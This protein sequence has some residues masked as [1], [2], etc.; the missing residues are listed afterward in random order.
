MKMESIVLNNIKVDIQQKGPF[1]DIGPIWFKIDG[2]WRYCMDHLCFFKKERPIRFTAYKIGD[3]KIQ[4]G[5]LTLINDKEQ[6]NAE[7]NLIKDN[8]I[9]VT[10][11]SRKLKKAEVH[12]VANFDKVNNLDYI[13]L[14]GTLYKN[15]NQKEVV[16]LKVNNIASFSG[17]WSITSRNTTISM[18][19]VNMAQLKNYRFKKNKKTTVL[20][21]R[22]KSMLNFFIFIGKNDYIQPI[23]ER[24]LNIEPLSVKNDE[25]DFEQKASK[26]F[27]ALKNLFSYKIKDGLIPANFNHYPMKKNERIKKSP[28]C[29]YGNCFSLGALYGTSALYLWKKEL[30][31]LDAL[32]KYILP[33]IRGSQIKDGYAKG[34]FF[35][36]FYTKYNKWTTGRV[37]FKGGGYSDWIPYVEPN[38]DQKVVGG[39]TLK[40]NLSII[41]RDI[42]LRKFGVVKFFGWGI[43]NDRK[44]APY[45]KK[46]ISVPVVFP[47]YTGQFCYF[48]LQIVEES[49]RNGNFLDTNLEAEII[50]CLTL[51]AEFLLKTQRENGIWDHEL[52]IDGRPFWKKETIACVFPATFLIWFGKMMKK[53]DYVE[54]GLQALNR[55]NALQDRNEYYGMYFETNLSVNQSDLVSGL[56]CIKCYGKLYELLEKEEYLDRAKRAAWHIVSSIWPNIVDKK[57]NNIAGG[58]MVTTYGGMGFPVIGGSELCQAFETF[59][60]LAKREPEF[61]SITKL[62]LNF[63]LKYLIREGK[64]SL[65]IYEIIFGYDGNWST[66]VSADFASYASGPFIRGLYLLNFIE[67]K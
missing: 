1:Y 67:Q 58:L 65:G 56:A 48:L 19:S 55:I 41:F 28:T 54:R 50:E 14:S 59:C 63:C 47:P 49:K 34:A 45:R 17:V 13:A 11:K 46:K 52:Y 9:V 42:W 7:F 44:T 6:I 27:F 40:E 62:I 36:T 18:I 8:L 22:F 66:S 38:F 24:F 39:F 51:S 23:K 61:L 2:N 15:I 43:K 5:S 31:V 10:L 53:D 60:E 16:E 30:E 37:Q 57:G 35:D 64:K 21:A 25:I 29:S 33:V 20:S 4:F 26:A 12:L 32:K 3:D